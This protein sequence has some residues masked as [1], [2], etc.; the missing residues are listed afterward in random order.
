[1]GLKMLFFYWII[2]FVYIAN[3]V[4]ATENDWI[5]LLYVSITCTY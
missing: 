1:M 2:N 4:L 5:D 3:F